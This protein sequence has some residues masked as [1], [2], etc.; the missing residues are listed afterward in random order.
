MFFIPTP[1]GHIVIDGGMPGHGR[2]VAKKIIKLGFDPGD[3]RI[4]L[5][6][7]AH[8]DHSGGLAELKAITGAQL[9]ASEDE[10]WALETGLV[11]GSEGMR[12]LRAPPVAVDRVIRDGEQFTIGNLEITALVTPGHT[13]GCTSWPFAMEQAGLDYEVLVFCS[14]SVSL[15]RL[16]DPPQYA[17]K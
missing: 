6:T 11:P 12:Y 17:S 15:N 7:H 2:L 4:Q 1:E 3:V 9:I 5:N 14:L 10:R 8:I 16:V 13:K